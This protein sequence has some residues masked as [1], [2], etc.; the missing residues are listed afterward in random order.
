[1]LIGAQIGK[2]HIG[3]NPALFPSGAYQKGQRLAN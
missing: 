1:M 2:E 3:P